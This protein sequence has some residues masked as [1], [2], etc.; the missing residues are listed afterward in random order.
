M[1]NP[2]ALLIDGKRTLLA[3]EDN[4]STR[5]VQYT[6]NEMLECFTS[7]EVAVLATGNYVEQ[8]NRFGGVRFIDMVATSIDLIEEG[9]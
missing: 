1:P 9:L 4:G 6:A 8:R 7:E 2:H 5:V 3:R